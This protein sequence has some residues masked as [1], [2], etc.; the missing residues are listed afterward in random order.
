MTDTRLDLTRIP[1]I[2]KILASRWLQWS[3]VAGT[4]PFFV[5]AILTGL[6]G[7]PAGNRNFGIVFVW[8][9]WWGLLM[10]V[11][12]PF[13]GRFWCAVC[14]IPAPGEWLQRRSLVQVHERGKLFTLGL[15]WPRQL[16][17]IWLQS[18]A[19]LIVALFAKVILTTPFVSAVTVLIFAGI[20]IATSLLFERRTFCRYIC[21]VGGF[22]GLYSQVAPIEVRV[23][24]HALCATHHDKA[25][26][27]GSEKGY[28]C[29]WLIFPAT[30]DKNTNCGLCTECLKTCTLDNIALSV[31]PF[32]KD[33]LTNKGRRLDEAYRSLMML[34]GAPL[35]TI[36][37]L[38][39]WAEIKEAAYAIASPGWW[40]YA[41]GLL[42]LTLVV[43]PGIFFACVALSKFIA[44]T[45]ASSRQFFVEYATALLPLGLGAWASFSLSFVLVNISY[46]WQVISDPF[47]WGWNLF[48][49][50]NWQWTPY[51]AGWQAYMQ[52]PI[53]LIGLV[54]A[55][56]IAF[57]TTG[58]QRGSSQAALPIVAFCV[59]FTLVMVGLNF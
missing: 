11:M 6:F 27:I 5:L 44:R 39:P 17:N 8:I 32:G 42:A 26:Y 49:T 22:I 40:L 4:L 10:L 57:R 7:T 29:P 55:I 23:K 36:V 37:F 16:N 43:V 53:L 33:L 58:E 56:A 52:I 51:L 14:P 3:L 24:D 38:G 46:A 2:K 13:A 15:K 34:A 31:R 12:V 35:Y 47:G 28:G 45:K 48:G 1:I 41:L 18:A 54:A 30:L 9:V 19:F 21:P 25:C 50:A 59:A 20:A